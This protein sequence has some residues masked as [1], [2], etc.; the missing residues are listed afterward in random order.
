MKP[1]DY[2]NLA[3]LLVIAALVYL[4]VTVCAGSDG[5]WLWPSKV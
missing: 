4:L 5:A 1:I 2:F 3:R